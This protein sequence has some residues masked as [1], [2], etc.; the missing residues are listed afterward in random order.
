MQIQERTSDTT[1]SN[2]NDVGQI[3]WNESQIY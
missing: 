3:K 1:L 2:Q